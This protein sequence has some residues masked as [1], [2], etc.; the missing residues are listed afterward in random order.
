MNVKVPPLAAVTP[1]INSVQEKIINIQSNLSGHSLSSG[2]L[3]KA[4]KLLPLITVILT[5]IKRSPLSSG[6]GH[7]K[8]GANELFLLS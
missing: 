1:V 6:R 7:P 5:S 3:S 2:Q 8:L 4:R